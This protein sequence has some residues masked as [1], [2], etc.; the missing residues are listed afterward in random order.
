MAERNLS[1]IAGEKIESDGG[2]DVDQ[3]ELGQINLVTA[4]EQRQR[5]SQRRGITIRACETRIAD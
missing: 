3:N 2:D 1:A 5:C 4:A